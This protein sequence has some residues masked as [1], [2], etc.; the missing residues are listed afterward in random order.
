MNKFAH[1]HWTSKI[2]IHSC[3]ENL[4]WFTNYSMYSFFPRC[5]QV[6]LSRLLYTL[7]CIC[8]CSGALILLLLL[9]P[10]PPPPHLPPSP[11]PTPPLL[12]LI[13]A[14]RLLLFIYALLLLLLAGEPLLVFSMY[15]L[16]PPPSNECQHGLK[17]E[18]E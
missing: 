7:L 18:R 12:L 1:A 3:L 13:Y 15:E 11:P 4:Y 2:G 8:I 10:P 14:L 5:Y 6:E 9:L 16:I 17:G